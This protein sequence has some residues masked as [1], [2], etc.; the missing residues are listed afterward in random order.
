[1]NYASIVYLLH[2]YFMFFIHEAYKCKSSVIS[3]MQ[4]VTSC[5]KR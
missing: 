1:M 3:S 2:K 4:K 5:M